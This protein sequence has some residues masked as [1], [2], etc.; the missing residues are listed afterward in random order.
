MLFC[1]ALP[2]L[3]S[4][5]GQ[6]KQKTFRL[7]MPVS[8]KNDTA[9]FRQ[10]IE[11]PMGKRIKD[12]SKITRIQE[13]A[14]CPDC[15]TPYGRW[16]Y[17]FELFDDSEPTKLITETICDGKTTVFNGE[18]LK[19]GAFRQGKIKSTTGGKD[20]SYT[21]F[22]QVTPKMQKIVEQEI[23]FGDSIIVN[24]RKISETSVL[25]YT[26]PGSGSQCDVDVTHF[27]KIL[28]QQQ[29]ITK[30]TLIQGETITI[31]GRE[32]AETEVMQ[33]TVEGLNGQCDTAVTNL[34]TV[35]QKQVDNRIHFFIEETAGFEPGKSPINNPFWVSTHLGVTVNH[36]RRWIWKVGLGWFPSMDF[37]IPKELSQL[38]L[39][40][41]SDEG[42]QDCN[43]DEKRQRF[44][45]HTGIAYSIPF[46]LKLFGGDTGIRLS[47][48][49]DYALGGAPVDD[50]KSSQWALPGAVDFQPAFFWQLP[51]KGG[52][53]VVAELGPSLQAL[54]GSNH[55]GG[56]I[57]V[58]FVMPAGKK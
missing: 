24:G 42:W 20:T 1:I 26:I 58:R 6:P 31:N 50:V 11:S 25:Y 12:V 29:K 13:T 34:I 8:V 51:L 57:R 15:P 56:Q 44:S 14:M 54:N 49:G 22:L 36:S 23:C 35:L 3:T 48:T 19:E 39:N 5:Q 38:S 21:Y 28:P 2:T 40:P 9:A 27:V 46:K 47:L 53:M 45:L 41:A 37:T 4:A 10:F 52:S 55:A 17:E 16:V 33:Y 18:V 43:C 7:E 30:D 32:I